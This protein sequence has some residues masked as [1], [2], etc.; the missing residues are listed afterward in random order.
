MGH[1]TSFP[2]IL[3][4]DAY[5]AFGP[6]ISP[7]DLYIAR[8]RPESRSQYR[9]IFNDKRR[10]QADRTS[11]RAGHQTIFFSFLQKS[12]APGFVLCSRNSQSGMKHYLLEAPARLIL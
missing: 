2:N 9:L 1:A 10:F 5:V 3:T 4:V 8:L 12:V 7:K 11:K 6:L